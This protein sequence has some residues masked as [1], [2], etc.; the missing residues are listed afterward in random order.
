MH[1]AREQ[2]FTLIELMIVVV[3]IAVIAAMALP[4]LLAARLSA[5]EAATIGTLR[6]LVSAQAQFQSRALVDRDLDGVGEFG[7]VAELAGSVFLRGS[8]RFVTPAI[9]SSSFRAINAQGEVSGKGY[10]YRLFLPDASGTGL[11]ELP[12]G[13]PA[14][15]IDEDLAES[16]WC[17]YAWPQ[18]YQ[19]S[20]VRT[21]FINQSGD[22][23]MTADKDYS[24]PGAFTHPGAAFRG[25]G[26]ADSITGIVA[27][28]LTGRDGNFWRQVQN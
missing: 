27:T 1:R 6:S 19:M 26:G 23:L 12:N 22:I 5:N 28:G 9:L 20:G 11:G 10:L 24:G 15:G 16:A 2:G 17:L 25:S 3:I 8:T 4:N 21:F 14:A 13:G 18:E 7:S